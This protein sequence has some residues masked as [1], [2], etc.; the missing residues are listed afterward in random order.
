MAFDITVVTIQL[1]FLP[2]NPQIN[3]SNLHPPLLSYISKYSNVQWKLPYENVNS[4]PKPGIFFLR[5]NGMN[6]KIL[7]TLS[8]VFNIRQLH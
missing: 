2:V 7:A 4:I 6:K 1:L 5:T 8:H 3:L